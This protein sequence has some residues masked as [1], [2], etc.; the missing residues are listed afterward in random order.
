M[1]APGRRPEVPLAASPG[2]RP[3]GGDLDRSQTLGLEN[4]DGETCI[5]FGVS[6]P[7]EKV[8]IK[9][10]AIRLK[11]PEDEKQMQTIIPPRNDGAVQHSQA[12][13]QDGFNRGIVS[14]EI[15]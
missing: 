2:P 10:H 11:V 4:T 13:L 15:L 9:H 1:E 8:I 12:R 5:R 6:P 14:S 7:S 3:V